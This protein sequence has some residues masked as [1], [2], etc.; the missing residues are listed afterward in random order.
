MTKHLTDSQFILRNIRELSKANVRHRRA[1]AAAAKA[2]S[3]A[4]DI[5]PNGRQGAPLLLINS[6]TVLQ[7]GEAIYIPLLNTE[8]RA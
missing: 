6:G 5:G 2:Y 3:N 1:H 4:A 7:G 8:R